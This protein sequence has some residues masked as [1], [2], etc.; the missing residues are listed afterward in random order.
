MKQQKTTEAKAPTKQGKRG[1]NY[2]HHS[3]LHGDARK[4][5]TAQNKAR[6]LATYVRWLE[7]RNSAPVLARKAERKAAKAA[8]KELAKAQQ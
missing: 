8:A 1:K 6:R 2:G 3:G 4:A 7:K 5:R